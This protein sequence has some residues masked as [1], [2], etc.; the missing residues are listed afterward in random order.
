VVIFFIFKK[1]VVESEKQKKM[2]KNPRPGITNLR[3]W[4]LAKKYK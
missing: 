2:G 4:N 1:C 3:K